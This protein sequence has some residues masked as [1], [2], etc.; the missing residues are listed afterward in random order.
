MSSDF[1]TQEILKRLKA[2]EEE[3]QRLKNNANSKPVKLT[4]VEGEYDGH[5]T[6]T[7]QGPFRQ[8][9]LG[10][11]KL[12]VVKETW[13]QIEAFLSK[14]ATTNSSFSQLDEDDFK[15]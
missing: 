10:L 4:V 15:I 5:P 13:P 12:K 8:F 1:D 9:T 11:K 2:L 3:N 7:F 14:H 6:L